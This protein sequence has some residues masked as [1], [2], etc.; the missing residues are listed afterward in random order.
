MTRDPPPHANGWRAIIEK[1]RA[2]LDE[3]PATT[4]SAS[5]I[6]D[7]QRQFDRMA[8]RL[9][10]FD[11]D[12]WKV[13]AQTKRASTW[14]KRRACIL[15]VLKC[16]IRERLASYD[17]LRHQLQ[18][19]P[20]ED[21]LWRTWKPTAEPLAG[22]CQ[23]YSTAPKD[24]PLVDREKRRSKRLLG[25]VP[26]DWRE[27]LADRLPLWRRPFV[28]AAVTG[29]RPCEL[30]KG[31]ILNVQGG[32]LTAFIPGGKVSKVSGQAWRKLSWDLKACESPLVLELAGL[33]T[34][35]GVAIEVNLGARNTNPARAFS[36]AIKA[37][38]KRAWPKRRGTITAYS[39]RHAAASDLKSSALSSQEVSQA[40]GHCAIA[41]K[42]S[43]GSVGRGLRLSTAPDKVDADRDVRG[44]P[45]MRPIH[46]SGPQQRDS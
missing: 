6:V 1:V 33:I 30:V 16:K 19:L 17:R 22:L 44:E 15:F 43:Y 37:A 42:G 3:S 8:A 36:D 45:S 24:S 9:S 40:L 28:V 23:I 39:L 10:E 7:Y 21:P 46:R 32:T 31:V 35:E 26:G 41:T 18:N 25:G 4:V 5:T 27:R 38:G 20:S 11:N 12:I 34:E 2:I 13:A 14:F 29:C